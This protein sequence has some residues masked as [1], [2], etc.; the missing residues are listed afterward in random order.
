ML[1][2]ST[3]ATQPLITLGQLWIMALCHGL[4]RLCVPAKTDNK[5]KDDNEEEDELN[6]EEAKKEHEQEHKQDKEVEDGSSSDGSADEPL[7]FQ[8]RGRRQQ[9]QPAVPSDPV[10]RASTSSPQKIGRSLTLMPWQ[11]NDR[12]RRKAYR[13][14]LFGAFSPVPCTLWGREGRLRG[15]SY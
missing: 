4:Y 7:A 11:T 2:R 5:E 6:E 3:D 14:A 15:S 9:S 10:H 1:F 13:K 12:N 8:G